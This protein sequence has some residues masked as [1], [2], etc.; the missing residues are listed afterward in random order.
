[1]HI[2][3]NYKHS[4]GTIHFINHSIIFF[5][6]I[7]P[8]SY[9]IC[10]YASFRE[11]MINDSLVW[12]SSAFHFLLTSA[13]ILLDT[14]LIGQWCIRCLRCTCFTSFSLPEDRGGVLVGAQPQAG[15]CF[16]VTRT[17]WLG[18]SRACSSQP[19]PPAMTGSQ[20]ATAPR[21]RAH[22]WSPGNRDVWLCFS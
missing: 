17:E 10:H 7:S 16:M 14:L 20:L 18:N 12:T 21:A 2:F 19:K 11:K 4:F 5:F 6:K 22:G 1:M 13:F 8:L 9:I 15:L 3:Q